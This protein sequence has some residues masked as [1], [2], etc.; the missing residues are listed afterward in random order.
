[1]TSVTSAPLDDET[2]SSLLFQAMG[3]AASGDAMR[4][5][6]GPG[7]PERRVLDAA[8]RCVGR[9]GLAKTT[10]DDVAREAG[11][12]RATVYRLFP[13][14]KE[15]VVEAVVAVE[16]ERLF[17]CLAVRIEGAG[18]LEDQLVQGILFASRTL[19]RHEALQYLL[20]HEP[21]Q[22][23]PHI[24]FSRFDRVLEAVSRFV[25]PYLAPHVGAALAERTA[26]WVTRLVL[27]YTLSASASFD[28][29]DEADVERFVAVFLLPGLR[30]A[31]PVPT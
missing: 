14:G 21:E 12:S 7:T 19:R 15:T 16:L 8:L 27:S 18:S 28:L 30:S 29:T 24:T 4:I 3:V 1:M 23:L 25:S 5:V 13:G 22:V 9:W 20:V 26:E 10:L 11:C 31:E 2:D 17:G 6:P